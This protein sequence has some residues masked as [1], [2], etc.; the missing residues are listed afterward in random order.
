MEDENL[1]ARSRELGERLLRE[2]EPLRE[3][4]AVGDVR[5]FL[6]ALSSSGQSHEGAR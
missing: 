6:P 3:H 4:P 2:L 5:G 1:I